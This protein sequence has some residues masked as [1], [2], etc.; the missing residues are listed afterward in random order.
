MPK[1]KSTA[2]LVVT[3][4]VISTIVIAIFALVFLNYLVPVYQITEDQIYSI[5]SKLFPIAIGL[6]MIQIGVSIARRHDIDYRDQLDKLPP[7][8]Y[9]KP[10]EQ[11]AKD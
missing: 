10:F 9:T 3:S 5:L 7:N 2:K 6:V 8:A 4:V 1:P 11:D